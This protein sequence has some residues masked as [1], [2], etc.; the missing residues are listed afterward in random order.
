MTRRKPSFGN[1]G[2]LLAGSAVAALLAVPA[3]ASA[4]IHEIVAAFCNGGGVGVTSPDGH[5]AAPGVSDPTKSNFAQ[6]VSSNGAT[7]IVN[8]PPLIRVE[9]AGSPSAKYPEGTVVV[10]AATMT[11]LQ[12]SQSDHPA[13][14]C[15]NFSSL[16]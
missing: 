8:P 3:T 2:R 14:H 15:K 11:F 7:V 13:T 1:L 9:I 5:L 6:P 16:P 12:V 4:T 10:D